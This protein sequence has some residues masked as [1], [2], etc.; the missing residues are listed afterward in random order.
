MRRFMAVFA[1]TG[2][3]LC[4]QTLPQLVRACAN[5]PLLKAAGAES[6]LYQ[7]RSEAAKSAR[8]PFLDARFSGT[9]LKDRPVV[10][11]QGSFSGLPPGTTL[12]TQSQELYFGALKLT[13]PLFT[14]FAL[15]AGIDAARAEAMKARL[16]EEDA[17]RN[18]YLQLIRAYAEAVAMEN[19]ARADGEALDAMEKSYEK[20]RGFYEKGL[21]AESDLLR[22]EADRFATKSSEIRHKNGYEAALLRLSYLSDTNVTQVGA[23]P[24][25]KRT[26]PNPLLA[27]ALSSRPD[28]RVLK[29]EL[30]LAQE[31]E[32]AAKSGY[33]PSVAL[34]GQLASQGDTWELDGDGYTNKDKSAAGFEVTYNL[35]S[36]F[37]T[38]HESEAAR[39][40]QLGAKWRI[41]AYE[42][43]IETEIR[44]SLL[45]LRWGGSDPAAAASRV[46]AEKAYY[47]KIQ[48]QFENQLADADLLSRAIASL[49]KARSEFSV[50]EAR[51]YA[52]Y[53][54]LLLQVGPATFEAALKE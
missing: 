20:A 26:D 38:A 47:A 14:G 45:S 36:G 5:A 41:T 22:I 43:Q 17:R 11:L 29:E 27:E 21:L 25:P 33:Y 48:G 19:L 34:F 3:L 40:A 9:Y 1:L 28:L 46:K 54:T 23:L 6:A 24:Q 50:A 8:Y 49:A 32:R 13:Y 37:K 52:S 51:L 16:K 10:F 12:Q 18:L 15:S 2:S 4:A 44:S 53:A 30:S 7:E 31:Q 35:F 42:K 39:K